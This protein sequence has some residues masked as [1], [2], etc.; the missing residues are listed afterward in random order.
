[1]SLEQDERLQNEI[2]LLEAMYPDQVAYNSKTRELKYTMDNSSFALRL[3]AGY[4][5]D[6]L[7]EVL[8]ASVG[9]VDQREQLRQQVK[10]LGPGEEVLDSIITAS[11]ELSETAAIGEHSRLLEASQATDASASSRATIVVWL[12]HLLNTN[13]RKLALSPPSSDVSGVT[14]PGYPGVLVYTGPSQAVHEH[15][16]DLKSQNWQAFQVRLEDDEAWAFSHGSGVKE[17]D[18]MKEVVAEVGEVKKEL[19]MEAMRMK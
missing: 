13:K 3:P 4:L 17:V 11:T 9:K 5:Q 8:S 7:P 10:T 2:S 12:H 6:S 1:M 18:S 16:N 14:K 19:F 15:V